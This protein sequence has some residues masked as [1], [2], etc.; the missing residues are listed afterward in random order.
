MG[1]PGDG[2]PALTALRGAG[3]DSHPVV[4]HA[5]PCAFAWAIETAENDPPFALVTGTA[6]WIPQ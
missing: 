6:T 3:R 5:P 2:R 4:G 1:S